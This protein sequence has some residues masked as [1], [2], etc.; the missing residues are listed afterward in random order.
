MSV[1]WTMTSSRRLGLFLLALHAL[2]FVLP[3]WSWVTESM[4]TTTI[5]RHGRTNS[6]FLLQRPQQQQHDDDYE[7]LSREAL[8][9]EQFKRRK[10]QVERKAVQTQWQRPPNP[11]L[12]PTELVAALLDALR[13]PQTQ[14]SGVVAL[15]ESSTNAWRQTLAQSVGAPTV[16][17]TAT[18][19]QVAPPLEI[20]LGRHGNQFAI[21]LGVE[22]GGY[23][24]DFPTDTL[25][26]GDGTCWVECRLRARAWTES[27]SDVETDELLVV[28][29]W[30]LHQRGTDGA[31]LVDG[32]DWQDFRA[33]YRPGIGREEWERICG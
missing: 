3:C 18:N 9:L 8:A 19:D 2:L 20:A 6:R 17:E 25:D 21:L 23:T 26:Y 28:M 29:G 15:L 27:E 5:R 7:D 30:S 10:S 22:D 32:L 31:W 4:T 16:P 13:Q 14:R 33:A 1:A 12:S 24:I 11:L